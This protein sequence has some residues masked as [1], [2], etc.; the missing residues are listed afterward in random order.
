M[1][2]SRRFDS[3]PATSG[4]PRG[5]AIV[6]PRQL[7]RFVLARNS[8]TDRERILCATGPQPS[9]SATAFSCYDDNHAGI[10][11]ADRHL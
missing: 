8:C 5:T 9:S 4:L 2:H 1:G 3:A 11:S 10:R 7:L 6:R